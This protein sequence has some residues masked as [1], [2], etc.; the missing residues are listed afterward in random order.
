MAKGKKGKNALIAILA[1]IVAFFLLIM[2]LGYSPGKAIP[3]SFNDG[4]I[5]FKSWFIPPEQ[6]SLPYNESED[7]PDD[8]PSGSWHED[9]YTGHSDVDGGSYAESTITFSGVGP[10]TPGDGG[11]TVS[12]Y[13]A[14]TDNEECSPCSPGVIWCIHDSDGTQIYHREEQIPVDGTQN[15][16]GVWDGMHPWVVFFGNN[17]PCQVYHTFRIRVHWF[18]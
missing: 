13:H 6:Y 8:E 9:D 4:F 2:Y 11:V 17:C 12:F 14:W 15:I 18:G 16:A 3:D 10:F 5:I 7:A 1:C